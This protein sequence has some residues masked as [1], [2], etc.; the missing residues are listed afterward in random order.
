VIAK[1]DIERNTLLVV[2]KAASIAYEHEC[3]KKRV[4]NINFFT[5]KM[6]LPSQS[7]NLS[8]VLFK[9]ANDPHLAREIYQL[10]PGPSIKREFNV[11]ELVVDTS[12]LE[13]IL[14]FNSFKTQSIDFNMDEDSS[15]ENA[16]RDSSG[17]WV[18]SS[19]FNHSCLP[20]TKI[21][22]FYDAMLIYTSKRFERFSHESKC[23]YNLF[24]F[25]QIEMLVKEKSCS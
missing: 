19:F 13:G 22:S 14:S 16:Q 8:N 7:Q 10:Y 15:K 9:V 18:F 6:D 25:F 3:S 23:Y 24:I 21:I 1:T 5:K 20:N 17:L 4:I 2:A 12:R 11:E